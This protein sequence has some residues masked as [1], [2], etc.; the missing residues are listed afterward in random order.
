[1]HK[2]FL[3]IALTNKC[4]LACEHCP[5][6]Q[7]RNS[8]PPKF[9]LNNSELIPFIERN[10]DISWVIELTG[11]EPA[12]YKGIDELCQ[13]LSRHAY[14]VLIKTNGMLPI[15]SYENVKRVAAYHQYNNF[16]KYYD[17]ILIVD[18]L[19]RDIKEEYC[20][21]NN[22]KYH[23]IGYNKENPDHA[24]HGFENI[25]YINP[26]GHQTECPASQ[27]IT[28]EVKKIWHA[29]LKKGTCYLEEIEE[30]DLHRIDHAT[31][32]LMK[33]CN[34]CKAAIDAWRF[35]D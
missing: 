22:I 28:N 11:G 13:W 3:Q 2:N 17:E 10:I 27:P 18:K 6:K 5:M 7:W 21:A 15:K 29:D 24:T 32:K 16:P 12:L 34:D 1:M 35:L 31:L 25:A 30:R 26:A 23:V 20:L 4:N 33:C 19:E 9:P 8:A 14:T